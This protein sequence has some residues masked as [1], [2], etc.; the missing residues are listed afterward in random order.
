MKVSTAIVTTIIIT[1]VATSARAQ[2]EKVE[3]AKCAAIAGPTERLT[4]FDALA[5]KLGVAAPRVSPAP[6]S[7]DTGKWQVSAETS[8]IDDSKNVYA[9]LQAQ[10]TISS[11]LGRA[12][13]TLILRCKE[14]KTEVFINWGVY[15]GLEETSVLTRLDDAK[16]T[17][18]TWGISTDN[19]ATFYRGGHIAFIKQLLGHQ[20][21]LVQVTPYG[22]K[23]AMVTFPIGPC[24]RL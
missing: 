5:K 6:S 13:P 14:K 7:G 20:R 18:S 12:R 11:M 17:S 4:C 23:P 8:P 10:E 19:K 1:C 16:A 3:I 15:L 22:E 2:N 21:L 9:M 24:Q